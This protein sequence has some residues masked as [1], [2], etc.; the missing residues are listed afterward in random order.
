[1][2]AL[3]GAEESYRVGS[4]E[5]FQEV[6]DLIYP[7]DEFDPLGLEDDPDA[8]AELKV[9]ELKNGRLAQVSALGFFVQAIVMGKGPLKNL[10]DHLADPTANNAWAYAQKFV[11]GA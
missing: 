4:L 10:A 7:G 2:V 11:P 5:G 6:Q 1:M 9:K 8:A 3:L